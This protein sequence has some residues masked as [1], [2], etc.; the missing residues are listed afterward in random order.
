MKLGAVLSRHGSAV[1]FSWVQAPGVSK[2]SLAESNTPATKGRR[3]KQR[4]T[5]PR[6]RV[7]PTP[8]GRSR[9]RGRRVRAGDGP[10]IAAYLACTGGRN[11]RQK[12]LGWA[13]HGFANGLGLSCK[14]SCEA[15]QESMVMATRDRIP[16]KFRRND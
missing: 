8:G 14:S 2:Q 13:G 10:F 9:P 11:A 6:L 16:P 7:P 1:A 4:R 3:L 12:P 5:R 15:V